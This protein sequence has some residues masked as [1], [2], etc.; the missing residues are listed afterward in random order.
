MKNG[1]AAAVQDGTL[2]NDAAES[3]LAR[4]GVTLTETGRRTLRAE[5]KLQPGPVTAF[6]FPF[7]VGFFQC[8]FQR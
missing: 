7:Q 2:L 4:M 8:V 6:P 5:R 1:N 3:L